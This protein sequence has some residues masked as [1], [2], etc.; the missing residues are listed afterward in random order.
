MAQISSSVRFAIIL[1]VIKRLRAKGSWCGETH[2]QKALFILQDATKSSFSYKF[3]MYKHG[4]YSF[5][6]KNELAAMK[7]SNVIEFKFPI[8]GYGPS[9]TATHFGERL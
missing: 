6:L 1:D 3:I 9:I 2:L 5:D 4:P 8:D 7:A